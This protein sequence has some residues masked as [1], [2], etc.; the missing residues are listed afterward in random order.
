[1]YIIYGANLLILIMLLV[2]AFSVR[3]PFVLFCGLVIAL[4]LLAVMTWVVCDDFKKEHVHFL[5]WVCALDWKRFLVF[6]MVFAYL[7]A[8]NSLYLVS[9]ITPDMH[10][11]F[12]AALA[13]LI[14]RVKPP[15]TFTE[16]VLTITFLFVIVITCMINVYNQ[17]RN[18]YRLWL[19]ARGFVRL[20]SVFMFLTCSIC[21]LSGDFTFWDAFKTPGQELVL[22]L[23]TSMV[24][25]TAF[26]DLALWFLTRRSPKYEEPNW[27]LINIIVIAIRL[28]VIF[29]SFFWGSLFCHLIIV[30]LVKIS[31]WIKW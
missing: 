29:L 18:A 16:V 30:I 6:S 8:Y 20:P 1:M 14:K 4:G 2:F 25:I 24:M 13:G 27:D 28:I 7:G 3:L 31:E 22:Y 26:L 11:S 10:H 9:E 21:Y 15:H 19:I 23:V 12:W 5:S 17:K